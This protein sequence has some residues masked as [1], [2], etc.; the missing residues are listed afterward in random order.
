MYATLRTMHTCM[1]VVVVMM[2]WCMW[3]VGGGGD[4]LLHKEDVDTT[5]EN[6]MECS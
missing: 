3:E 4:K 6:E 5:K 1:Y 2:V